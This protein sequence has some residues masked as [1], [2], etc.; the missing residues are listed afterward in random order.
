MLDLVPV[1]KIR[2]ILRDNKV[3]AVVGLSPKP[4]RP[5]NQV[6]RYMLDAGYRVIPVNP[7][8]DEILGLPC[9]PDLLSVPEDVDI[10]TI[11]RRPDEVMPV[12]RDAVA[13]GARVVWMQQGIIN[14]EAAKLAEEN[15]LQVIMD[16]CIKV[17]HQQLNTGES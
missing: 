14:E 7:G 4:E 10:V 6:A 2:A 12:V 1:Q 11:F 5:S 17:D 8:Q 15:G 13:K 9:Y 16:R 3:I